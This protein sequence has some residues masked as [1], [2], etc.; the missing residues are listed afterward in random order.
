MLFL[1]D[2]L[3]VSVVSDQWDGANSLPYYLSEA[4]DFRK[5][6]F[7]ND[8]SCIFAETRGEL[9]T[10]NTIAKQFSVIHS[11]LK[12]PIVLKIQGL[13]DERRKALIQSR[14]PF[15]TD[16]QIYLPFLGILL[17]NELYAEPKAREKL[18]PSAQML[19]FKYL[20]SN[21]NKMYTSTM[22]EKIGVSSM[23]ITRAVRQLKKFNLF[24]VS[25][26][27]VQLV[28][29][30]KLNRRALFEAATPYLL[31]P[32]RDILY[33]KRNEQAEQLP[34]AGISALSE[35]SMLAA[36]SLRTVAFY[37]KSDKIH[38][39]NGLTDSERQVR[40]EIWKYDPLALS[41]KK[42]IA[43][44]LSVIVSLKNEKPDERVDQAID[45]ILSNL[46]G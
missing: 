22:S 1:S 43:D 4:Y 38:G 30:G 35:N 15:V 9:P 27:G 44:L 2:A 8:I 46:W 21:G 41:S 32:V 29:E 34:L 45:K 42:N 14:V 11:A 13:P 16:T 33:I 40:V 10:V 18:M 28:V 20:Y 25:K 39:E 19:L 26:E 17:R 5:V 36:S 7:N 24:D 12:L 31:D 23:Q 37:S 6:I 3:G